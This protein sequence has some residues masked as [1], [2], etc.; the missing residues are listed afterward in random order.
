EDHFG[1]MALSDIKLTATANYRVKREREVSFVTV[2]RELAFVR[3]LLNLALED[4]VLEAAPRIRLKNEHDRIRTRTVTAE[5]YATVLSHM[6]REQQRYYIALWETAMRLREPLKV[7]W[8]KVDL[9]AGLIRLKAE[10][11]KEKYPRRI[12]ISWE[13]RQVLE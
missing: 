12:P 8:A 3:Y 2:N 6:G 11:V 4:G 7:T 10:D 1:P 9:K 5:E 13:L